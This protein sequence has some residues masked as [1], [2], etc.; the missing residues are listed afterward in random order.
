L[1]SFTQKI[2]KKSAYWHRH[3]KH[4]KLD[5]RLIANDRKRRDDTVWFSDIRDL[6]RRR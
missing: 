6:F 1:S 3:G 5:P 4:A 2:V